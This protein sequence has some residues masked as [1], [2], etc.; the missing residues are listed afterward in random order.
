[1]QPLPPREVCRVLRNPGMAI[2]GV[3]GMV[4]ATM[5]VIASPARAD[6][7]VLSRAEA[8]V[9]APVTVQP[10]IDD[11]INS[12]RKCSVF[13][14]NHADP[15]A[16]FACGSYEKGG[17]ATI[18]LRAPAP[19][20]SYVMTVTCPTCASTVYEGESWSAKANFTTLSTVPA[21]IGL[22]YRDAAVKQRLDDAGL[23]LGSQT[24][25]PGPGAKVISQ[26][27]KAGVVI[28]PGAPV[29]LVYQMTQPPPL[30]N[31]PDLS[32]LGR[33]DAAKLLIGKQL[34]LGTVTG[35]GR[36]TT[37]DPQAGT[38]VPRGSPVNVVLTRPLTPIEPVVVPDLTG[39]TEQDAARVLVA[40]RLK[41]GPATGTGRIIEQDPPAQSWALTDSKVRVKLGQS[42][43][44]PFVAVPDVKG[45][46]GPDAARRLDGHRLILGTVTGA[47]RVSK[48]LPEA[49]A[50]VA[51]GT[52]VNIMLTSPPPSL[53]TVPDIRGL[54]VSDAGTRIRDDGL[55][56]ATEGATTGL[57]VSQRPPAGS[58]M[59]KGST[60]TATVRQLPV[61]LTATHRPIRW[62][63]I[64][65]LA[66]AALMVSTAGWLTRKRWPKVRTASRGLPRRYPPAG[67][68]V[69][70][71]CQ[72]TPPNLKITTVG[73]TAFPVQVTVHGRDPNI[74]LKE[75]QT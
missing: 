1:L 19:P 6:E 72:A 73:S 21:L 12:E 41:L 48:Q 3:V 33:A 25:S 71:R 69:D 8:P 45:L 35:T 49:G 31:V 5:L 29:D 67:K 54:K 66:L 74:K 46:S 23:L 59:A 63:G 75:V 4:L 62:D 36:I 28:Q 17:F 47:G 52:A 56:L 9:G 51:P 38:P 20:H 50:E 61:V 37:Q 30:V 10:L 24:G 42:Q 58:R 40:H 13:W 57:V 70:V 18:E 32:D 15:V 53:V 22:S 27:P 11:L 34:R 16:T 39:L 60:V 43:L 44:D 55:K 14:D 68:H 64:A 26:N 2:T 7:L 65:I